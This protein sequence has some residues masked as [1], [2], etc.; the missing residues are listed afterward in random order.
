MSLHTVERYSTGTY[1]NIFELH[2]LMQYT[3]Y[4]QN[5]NNSNKTLKMFP[6]FVSLWF[7]ITLIAQKYLLP[8]SYKI[9]EFH[10]VCSYDWSLSNLLLLNLSST[11][12]K[13]HLMALI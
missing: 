3:T 12:V 13:K 7:N 5:I 4:E 8:P 9:L 2:V 11:N 1:T 10:L 6:Y